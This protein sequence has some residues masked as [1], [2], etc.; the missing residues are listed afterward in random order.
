MKTDTIFDRCIFEKIEKPNEFVKDFSK[1]INDT[2]EKHGINFVSL[3]SLRLDN[4]IAVISG[5]FEGTFHH[6]VVS[7]YVEN[8][9][10]NN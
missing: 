3:H 6:G 1:A 5:V 8:E 10:I 7:Q 9:I 4:N 2:F